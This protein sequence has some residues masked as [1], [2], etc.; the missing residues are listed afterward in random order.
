VGIDYDEINRKNKAKWK[1]EAADKEAKTRSKENKKSR[2]SFFGFG[3]KSGETSGQASAQHAKKVR[4]RRDALARKNKQD[5]ATKSHYQKNIDKRKKQEAEH[6]QSKSDWKDGGVV[7]SPCN[8]SKIM[9][10]IKKKK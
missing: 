10:A 9:K 3:K 2:S 1:Q 8:F 4:E 5:S 6:A 7:K